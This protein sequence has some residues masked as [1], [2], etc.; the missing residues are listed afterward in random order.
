MIRGLIVTESGRQVVLLG[1]EPENIARIVG[2]EPLTVNLR[3][4]GGEGTRPTDLPP[5]DIAICTSADAEA[6]AATLNL[7]PPPSPN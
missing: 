5:I 1:L 4:L 2:G 7:P 6:F 3:M